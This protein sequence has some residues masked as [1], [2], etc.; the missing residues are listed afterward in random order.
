MDG[1]KHLRMIVINVLSGRRTWEEQICRR[2]GSVT[3]KN[4][5]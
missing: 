5:R 3:F 1:C 4:F 2:C